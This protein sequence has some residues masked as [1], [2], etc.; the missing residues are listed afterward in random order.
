VDFVSYF[1]LRE[2]VFQSLEKSERI[3]KFYSLFVDRMGERIRFEEPLS[4]HSSLRIGGPAAL[5]AEPNT[6]SELVELLSAAQDAG[7]HHTVVGLG[8]NT[9]FSDDGIDGLVLRL[10]GE[11]ANW[12]VDDEVLS[13]G[14]GAINAHLVRAMFKEGWVGME[15]LALIPGTLGGAVV[16]NAGTQEKE[17]SSILVD[18]D[19]IDPTQP[20]MVRTMSREE[21]QMSYRHACL[22]TGVVVASARLRVQQG[23]VEAAALR[24]RADKDRRNL[25]QPYKLASVGSTFANPPGDYAGRLIEAVGLKGVAVGGARVSELHGNFFINEDNASALDFLT[26]MAMARVRVRKAHQIELRPEVSFVGFDGWSQLAQIE[27]ELE[28]AS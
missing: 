2:R 10:A 24:V 7:I 27:Q 25:T 4:K 15:F 18:I 8:S 19:V 22:D 6:S 23:D 11:L 12:R 3:S 5:W 1:H 21:L 16:M 28:A 17:L 14:G 26:L 13:V 9:L 20:R